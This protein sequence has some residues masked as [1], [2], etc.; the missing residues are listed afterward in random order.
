[1]GR[2]NLE[3]RTCCSRRAPF[4]V[5][6]LLIL[7]YAEFYFRLE[8]SCVSR[9]NSIKML[10]WWFFSFPKICSSKSKN[11]ASKVFARSFFEESKCFEQSMSNAR[12]SRNKWHSVL[13]NKNS[14]KMDKNA[15]IKFSITVYSTLSNRFFLEII[16][17]FL[18]LK[19]ILFYLLLLVVYFWSKVKYIFGLQ[20]G[21]SSL[22]HTIMSP[23]FAHQARVANCPNEQSKKRRHYIFDKNATMNHYSFSSSEF[24]HFTLNYEKWWK[25]FYSLFFL[26]FFQVFRCI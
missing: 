9:N 21:N 23:N 16:E 24:H 25:I 10:Q 19:N 13:L 1:M 7:Q 26:S 11:F 14:Q 3:K 15:K 18:S 6:A 12:C 20:S 2:K 17:F 22:H 8:Y 5:G 4:W